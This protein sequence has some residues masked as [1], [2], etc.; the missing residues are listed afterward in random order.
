MSWFALWQS[1]LRQ[2]ES[3]AAAA[4]SKYEV[5][6]EQY[7]QSARQTMQQMERQQVRCRS[8]DGRAR[9][10]TH[11]PTTRTHTHTP[12]HTTTGEHTREH[13][14]LTLTHTTRTHTLPPCLTHT[15]TDNDNVLAPTYADAPLTHGHTR[16][17]THL[18]PPTR[19]YDH[20]P[21]WSATPHSSHTH[22]VC[23]LVAVG[24]RW[25]LS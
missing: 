17:H 14:H 8:R 6:N 7:A 20:I 4:P 25:P 13:T 2:E 15:T 9:P 24:N 22:P 21:A 5:A 18:N 10:C 3:K 1:L 19:T 16:K 11:T 23:C 12:I